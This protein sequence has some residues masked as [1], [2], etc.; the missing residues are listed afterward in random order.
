MKHTFY[1]RDCQA[2]RARNDNRQGQSLVEAVVVIGMV[3][4]LVSGLIVG[5]TVSLRSS[6]LGRSRS[7]A[8][9][10]ATEGI[11]YARNLRNVGWTDFQ[12]KTGAWCLDKDKTLTQAVSGVCSANI[13]SMFARK[14]TFSWTDPKMTVTVAITWNDGSGD[15]KSELLTY[16]TQWR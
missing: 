12:A 3:I 15:H 2:H 8:V 5:T 11:E 1:K 16:F 14:L 10:Y 13:D 9:K 4:V 7:L 6:E